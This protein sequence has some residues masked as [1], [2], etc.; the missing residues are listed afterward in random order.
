MKTVAVR[1]SAHGLYRFAQWLS[2]WII[3]LLWIVNLGLSQ[4]PVC[5]TSRSS[6]FDRGAEYDS[7]NPRFR[8]KDQTQ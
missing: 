7:R 3:D 4:A 2:L 5:R 8:E 6:R 1:R